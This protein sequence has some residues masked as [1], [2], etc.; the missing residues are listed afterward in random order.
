MQTR[1]WRPVALAALLALA[2]CAPAAA[3]AGDEAAYRARRLALVRDIAASGVR[4]SAVL[5]AMRSV[6]R[7][8]FVHPEYRAQAYEDHPLP[9]ELGQTISQPSVVATMTELLRPRPGMKVLEI[10]TG[11]GYQAALLARIGCRVFTIE[12]LERLAS[13]ARERLKRLG[14]GGVAVRTGDGYLGWPEEAPF[15]GIIV[16]AGA[17]QVPVELVRELARG[18]RMVVPVDNPG[19]YQDL[20]LVEKDARGAVRTTT[21][22]PVEF[23]PLVHGH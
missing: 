9:T 11:S 17:P 1:T 18:G 12:I 22:M 13:T 19:G 2:G 15:E 7:H 4:D 6:P 10:G 3:P 8:E 21:L 14:Y 20:T 23:V 5:E 16:T